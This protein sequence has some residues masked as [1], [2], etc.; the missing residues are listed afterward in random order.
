MARPVF[1]GQT[2]STSTRGF[3]TALAAFSGMRRVMDFAVWK[4]RREGR[5]VEQL[6]SGE[7]D[8]ARFLLVLSG[9]I[10]VQIGCGFF[11]PWSGEFFQTFWV[12]PSISVGL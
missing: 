4:V 10:R 11:S 3:S 7:L 6:S 2:I 5:P 1:G 8:L 12:G 9:P